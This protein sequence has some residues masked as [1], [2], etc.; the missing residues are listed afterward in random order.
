MSRSLGII[1]DSFALRS[2]AFA[3]VGHVFFSF[4]GCQFDSF[5]L[6]S[7]KVADVPSLSYTQPPMYGKKTR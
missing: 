2:R 4:S 1:S 7:W 3:L 6:A 5:R